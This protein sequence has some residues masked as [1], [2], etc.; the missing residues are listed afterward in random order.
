MGGGVMHLRVL[1]GRAESR[2][3]H[4]L[5]ASA[6]DRCAGHLIET[7][8]G[9]AAPGFDS[10]RAKLFSRAEKAVRLDDKQGKTK[11]KCR[12]DQ[13]HR[14]VASLHHALMRASPDTLSGLSPPDGTIDPEGLNPVETF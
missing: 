13:E 2:L 5:G 11:P 14:G 8:E 3:C 1:A 6:F 12:S 10:C 7:G 4:Q 9:D